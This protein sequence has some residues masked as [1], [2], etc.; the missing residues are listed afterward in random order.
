MDTT[1]EE[2]HPPA[3]P[4]HPVE[5][6]KTESVPVKKKLPRSTVILL[7]VVAVLLIGITVF[8][9]AK[10]AA[11]VPEP[12]SLTPTTVAPSVT[13]IPSTVT[14]PTPS[15]PAASPTKTVSSDWSIYKN[16]AY[17][18]EIS[19]PKPYKMLDSKDDLSAYPQ[20][21]VLIYKGGQAYDV[22]IEVWD[23]K[24]AYETNYG[25][26]VSDLTVI[27][28]KGKFITLLDNTGEP[29]NEKIIASFKLN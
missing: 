8:F 25:S 10:N 21:I 13:A 3:H 20:G 4:D 7:A 26:R 28:S 11:P 1:M 22:I 2:K 19:F 12:A 27:E 9:L 6:E 18:F 14:L 5:P 23:A 16:A 29:D 15:S 17:G 24:A